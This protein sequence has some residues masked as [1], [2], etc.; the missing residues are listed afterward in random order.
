AFPAFYP[1]PQ[2]SVEGAEGYADNPGAWCTEAGFVTSGPFTCTEWKHNE[3]MT[4]EPNPNYYAADKVSLTKIQF[5]LSSDDTAIY[6]A[7]K[8]GTLQFTDTV[9][10][11]IMETVK[12]TPEFHKMS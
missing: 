1:V 10:T 2:A 5:M 4:Y 11:D 7:F 12:D 9:A 8:S 6:N 3:S